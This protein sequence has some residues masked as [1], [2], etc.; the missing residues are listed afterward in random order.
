[1]P[2]HRHGAESLAATEDATRSGTLS[3]RRFDPAV[4]AGQHAD[5]PP[6]DSPA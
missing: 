5:E 2:S 4:E 3:G 1:M 6:A